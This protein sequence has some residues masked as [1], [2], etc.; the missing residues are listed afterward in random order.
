MPYLTYETLIQIK[1][2]HLLS[3]SPPQ[4]FGASLHEGLI[5]HDRESILDAGNSLDP[6]IDIAANIFVLFQMKLHHQVK[7]P[8]N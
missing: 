1:K 3:K 5:G 8:G 4:G 2:V 7:G 6:V